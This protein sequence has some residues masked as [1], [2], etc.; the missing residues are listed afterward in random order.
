MKK[1]KEKVSQNES[2]QECN[3]NNNN[4]ENQEFEN[5]SNWSES[6]NDFDT[7][8]GFKD[9]TDSLESKSDTDCDDMDQGK[10]FRYK[11]ALRTAKHAANCGKV[12][13]AKRN[14]FKRLFCFKEIKIFRRAEV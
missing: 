11:D 8:S 5:E 7:D 4:I 14:L 12:W 10:H 1:N 6:V 9:E 13:K 3:I 2:K